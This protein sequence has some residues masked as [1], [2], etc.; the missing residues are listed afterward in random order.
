M[1]AAA[2]LTPSDVAVA[3]RQAGAIRTQLHE[4]LRNRVMVIP[5]VPVTA[6]T[7]ELARTPELR[8]QLLALTVAASLG[9][10]P[11]LT[12][13][14]TTPEGLPVGLCLVGPPDSDETLF[15]LARALSR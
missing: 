1:R 6:P 2:A 14:F 10:L 12:V 5:T 4:V 8:S 7:P 13:P 3:Q 15:P 11:A 9:G